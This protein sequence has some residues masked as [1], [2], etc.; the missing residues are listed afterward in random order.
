MHFVWYGEA[1]KAVNKIIDHRFTILIKFKKKK[2][3]KELIEM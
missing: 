3:K 1:E 2:K